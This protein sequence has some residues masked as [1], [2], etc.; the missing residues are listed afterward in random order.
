MM[1]AVATQDALQAGLFGPGEVVPKVADR[2]G[3]VVAIM[4][5]GYSL[6]TEAERPTAHKM[7]GRHGGMNHAEMLVPWL[8]LRLDGW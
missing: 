3:D 8:G 6:F 7:I 4:R 5:D 1:T 2:F